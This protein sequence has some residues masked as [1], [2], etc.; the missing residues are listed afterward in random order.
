MLFIDDSI[1]DGLLADTVIDQVI[2]SV[3]KYYLCQ[4]VMCIDDVLQRANDYIDVLLSIWSDSDVM[5]EENYDLLF[6][7]MYEG[8][9]LMKGIT[10]AP[11]DSYLLLVE[12]WY[13]DI[14][15]LMYIWKL[16]GSLNDM[17]D[18]DD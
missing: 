11:S 15:K 4:P 6:C 2:P 13:N 10:E 1:I 14:E 18:D 7:Y 8:K 12:E 5:E 3:E 16:F 9:W 17:F